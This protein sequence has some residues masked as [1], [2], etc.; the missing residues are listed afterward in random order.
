MD[1]NQINN[2]Q[3]ESNQVNNNQIENNQ[4]DNNQIPIS[5]SNEQKKNEPVGSSIGTIFLLLIVVGIVTA[6]FLNK[7]CRMKNRFQLELLLSLVN[8]HLLIV[9]HQSSF[10]IH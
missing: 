2:S 8:H 1:N 4:V 7:E 10:N 9:N 5:P 6:I 3:V